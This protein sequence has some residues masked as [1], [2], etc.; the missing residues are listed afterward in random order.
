[1]LIPPSARHLSGMSTPKKSDL[2]LD[3]MSVDDLRKVTGRLKL[4]AQTKASEMEA[5]EKGQV[6]KAQELGA[7]C[8]RIFASLP[9]SL[10]W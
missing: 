8:D 6:R 9:K 10:R 5:R 1:M 3:G 2:N 4:Y 7:L